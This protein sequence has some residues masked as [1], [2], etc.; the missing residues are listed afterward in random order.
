MSMALDLAK[1]PWNTMRH[2]VDAT[3]KEKLCEEAVKWRGGEPPPKNRLQAPGEQVILAGLK[4]RPELNGVTGQ[5]LS[6]IAD[7]E[8]FLIVQIPESAGKDQVPPATPGGAGGDGKFRNVKVQPRCLHPIRHPSDPRPRGGRLQ[9][10][11]SSATAESVVSCC[12]PAA[13]STVSSAAPRLQ[14]RSTVLKRSGSD[15]V[16]GLEPDRA[17][18][19]LSRLPGRR[20][21]AAGPPKG[22]PLYPNFP[23]NYAHLVK[24]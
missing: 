17:G 7:D 19:E 16:V 1:T 3:R 20:T 2:I 23:L 13:A 18:S 14:E 5:I 10:F 21:P 12:P 8:G 24:H 11:E 15:V 6:R 4:S 9:A 22:T